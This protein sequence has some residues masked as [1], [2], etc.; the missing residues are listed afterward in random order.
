[1]EFTL[2]ETHKGNGTYKESIKLI[3]LSCRRSSVLSTLKVVPKESSNKLKANV[4][5]SPP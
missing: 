2:K 5:S 1:M 3:A 4:L